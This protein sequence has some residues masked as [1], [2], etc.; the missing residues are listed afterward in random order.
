MKI[1]III[2][3]ILAL[4]I[5]G[6][7]TNKIAWRNANLNCMT[8]ASCL[9]EINYIAYSRYGISDEASSLAK[10]IS[11]FG[12]PALVKLLELL[13]SDDPTTLKVAGYAIS[14]FNKIDPQY[15]PAIKAGIEKNIPWL[16][17][18]LGAIQSDEAARY[19]VE[20]YLAASSSPSNQEAIAVERQGKRALPFI[21]EQ[22]K[23]DNTCDKTK[24]DL[25]IQI[26][27]KMNDEVKQAA[28]KDIISEISDPTLSVQSKQNLVALFF[29]M[30]EP[31]KFV[32][33]QLYHIRNKNPDLQST[34]DIAFIGIKSKYSGRVFA[35]YL[36]TSP[37]IYLLR[38]IAEAGPAA[39]DAGP[40]LIDLLSH[41]DRDL[42]LGAAQ[43][44]GYL[45]Y[46]E[47][48]PLL[49]PLLADKSDV[50]L[51]WAVANTLGMLAQPE[52][53]EPLESVATSHWYPAVR[54]AARKAADQIKNPMADETQVDK[55]RLVPA[56]FGYQHFEIK[57]CKE[58]SL[59]AVS[60]PPSHK[61]NRSMKDTEKKHLAYE[62]YIISYGPSDEKEQ[63]EK[64]PDG[65]IEVNQYN[66]V[67]HK[68]AVEQ[69]P[70][71]ALKIEDGW[72]AGSDRGEW[73][74]ELVFIPNTGKAVTLINKNVEDIYKFG[75]KYV[76]VSG[77][78]H[79]LLNDG[80]V[81]QLNRKDNLWYIEPWINLPGAPAS[82]WLVD[83][84][85][86]LVNTYSGGSILIS[87]NGDLRMAP[88]KK[89]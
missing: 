11:D 82:S 28:A 37:S 59:S 42:R 14:R 56:F 26:V 80:E 24:V 68:R 64:D 7:M 23:C 54:E 83:T 2:P 49:I 87:E 13:K 48:L 9:N 85:E 20:I 39:R 33:E 51:N 84:G 43:A 58:T 1:R 47:A 16:P 88:C 72:L 25:L 66:I 6:C 3:M 32:E 4:L 78:A 65:I 79:M 69:I 86:L 19:S 53:L 76:V 60:E 29:Q 38:D 61:L 31:G 70:D 21:F 67:E 63:R 55:N 77:L 73:G 41:P 46:V 17:R 89:N 52:S 75:D 81:F 30:G 74:G 18:A 34:I 27:G 45:Q 22:A 35:S 10:R 40:A 71:V 50:R 62:T 15:F 8:L 36:K 5:C 57:G 44:L 12:K